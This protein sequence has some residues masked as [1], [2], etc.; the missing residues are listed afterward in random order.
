MREGRNTS[1]IIIAILI[2]VPCFFGWSVVRMRS[3][4]KGDVGSQEPVEM[5][6]AEEVLIEPTA[7][8]PSGPTPTPGP[9]GSEALPGGLQRSPTATPTPVTSGNKIAFTSER[10]GNLEVYVMNSDGSNLT[11]L[12]NQRVE[13]WAASWMGPDRLVIS[14]V[15][16]M[17]R[18]LVAMNSD[19][20][21]QVPL[22]RLP[23]DGYDFIWSADGSSLAFARTFGG[24]TDLFVAQADGSRGLNLTRDEFRDGYPAW[25]PDNQRL[26]FASRRDGSKLNQLYLIN[27]DGTNLTRLLESDYDSHSPRWSPDGT[28]IAFVAVVSEDESDIFV[29]DSD[30][31]NLTRLTEAQ[32]N[33]VAP[34]WSPD[35]QRLV[36]QS[37]RDGN[38]NVYVMDGDGANPRRLTDDPADDIRPLWS[39]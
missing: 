14:T 28:R 31:S 21:D 2:L 22:E 10:D 3:G 37:E 26:V 19:G 34:S 35:S 4:L 8:L 23:E 15:G 12:T 13:D 29:V 36:F 9:G 33:D 30:G 17:G 27:R 38:W 11:R 6:E 7:T 20:S 16:P 1:I 18:L 32:G 5:P 25:A 24:N 39:P